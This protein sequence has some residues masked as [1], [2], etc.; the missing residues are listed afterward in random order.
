MKK[1]FESFLMD[2]HAEEYIGTDDCMV[3][4]FP[5]WLDLGEKYKKAGEL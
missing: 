3:D 1:D 4:D 5:E 2:K